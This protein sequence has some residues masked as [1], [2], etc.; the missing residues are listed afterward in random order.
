MKNTAVKLI[1]AL[2]I[3]L[4]PYPLLGQQ[5][6]APVYQDGDW[7]KVKIEFDFKDGYNRSGECYESYPEYLVKIEQGRPKIYGISGLGQEKI[8]CPEIR[9]EVLGKGRTKNLKFPLSLGLTW[10]GRGIGKKK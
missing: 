3:V 5:A 9:D 4:F 8:D 6:E 7:W 10:T 2:L 1:G